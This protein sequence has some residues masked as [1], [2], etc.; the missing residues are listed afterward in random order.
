L[1]ALP[2][3]VSAKILLLNT[4]LGQKVTPAELARRLGTSPQVVNRIVDIEH[5]TKIDTIAEALEALGKHLEL[6]VV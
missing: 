6:A 4:M 1:V 3:S 2:A 5:A